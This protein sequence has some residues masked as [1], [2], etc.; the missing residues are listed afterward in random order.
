MLVERAQRLVG[1]TR[2]TMGAVAHVHGSPPPAQPFASVQRR[3]DTAIAMRARKPPAT[4]VGEIDGGEQRVEV[5]RRQP[6][7]RAQ[8]CERA[9]A[10]LRAEMIVPL[11]E[12]RVRT[13]CRLPRSQA[14]RH[15]LVHSRRPILASTHRKWRRVGAAVLDA[16][17]G[18]RRDGAVPAVPGRHARELASVREPVVRRE[19]AQSVHFEAWVRHLARIRRQG[20]GDRGVVLEPARLGLRE[21]EDHGLLVVH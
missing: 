13:H 11:D 9:V 3:A 8:P 16:R 1:S 15:G 18:L 21:V 2:A 14:R 10:L 7:P 4:R 19:R 17:G 6:R 12:R 20:G 5:Q